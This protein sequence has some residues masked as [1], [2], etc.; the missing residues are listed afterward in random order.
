M[1]S[2]KD[3][4]WLRDNCPDLYFDYEEQIIRGEMY[5][6]M[7]FSSNEERYIINPDSSHDV[8]NGVV[9]ED[10]YEIEIN[11]SDSRLVPLVKETGGRILKSKEK[12]HLKSLSDLHINYNKTACLCVKTE[13]HSK[14][15]RGF[16]LKDFF[17]NLLIPFFYYQSFFEKYGR[18]PWKG[19]SH[20]DLGILENYLS[21]NVCTAKTI[22]LFCE[23][24]ST[25]LRIHITDN[26]IFKKYHLCFCNSGKQFKKCHK[27]AFYGYDKLRKDFR[28]IV[29]PEISKK[30]KRNQTHS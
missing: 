26:K 7:Y 22:V 21:I 8:Y 14:M 4:V 1:L 25:I 17:E 19:Y 9:I 6:K 10:V 29:F 20:G 11:L 27:K 2:E 23:N 15:P 5:F 18:E 12:W 28:K 3:E 24:L 30:T 13:E 16:N